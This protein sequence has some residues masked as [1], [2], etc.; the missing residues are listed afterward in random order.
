MELSSVVH[1]PKGGDRT[2]PSNYRPISR[3]SVVSK[4]LEHHV[5]YKVFE[6]VLYVVWNQILSR[7]VTFHGLKSPLSVS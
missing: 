4:M 5:H 6:Q 7:A 1:I 3:L 2:N